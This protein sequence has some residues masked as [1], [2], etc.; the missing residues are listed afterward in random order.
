MKNI[1]LLLVEDNEG[2]ILLTREA[3]ES[4]QVNCDIEIAKN[5]I[6]AI[7][8]LSSKLLETPTSLPEL[9]FLDINLPKKNGQDVLIF[10]KTHPNL[11]HI[12]TIM[13]TTSSYEKD[14]E[15]SYQN[16]ANC[17]ITKPVDAYEYIEVVGKL[18]DFWLNI[19]KIPPYKNQ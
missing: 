13:L 7:E 15:L 5:G 19:A 17:Y 11:K 10:I 3:L 9:I 4:V 16:Q 2:D 18:M 6:K 12:P 14:I 8:L 1:K